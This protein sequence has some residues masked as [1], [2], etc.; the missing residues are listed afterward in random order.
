MEV[1]LIVTMRIVS[2]VTMMVVSMVLD[3]VLVDTMQALAERHK[4]IYFNRSIINKHNCDHFIIY[5]GKYY[6]LVQKHNKKASKMR[7][8]TEIITKIICIK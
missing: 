7:V 6:I 5:W 2:R 1:A 8:C 3:L 4:V